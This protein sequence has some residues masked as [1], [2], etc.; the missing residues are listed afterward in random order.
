ML[1][2]EILAIGSKEVLIT[3][4]LAAGRLDRPQQLMHQRS[5]W[6]SAATR[7]LVTRDDEDFG[8]SSGFNTRGRFVTR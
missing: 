4:A 7:A 3:Y 1:Q 5:T 8:C 2:V 6:R